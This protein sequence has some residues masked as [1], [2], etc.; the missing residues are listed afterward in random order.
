M[1]TLTVAVA[2]DDAAFRGTVADLLREHGLEVLEAADG[3]M[4]LGILQRTKVALVVT[5]LA[6][7]RLQG[8][9]VLS[10][11]RVSGDDTP[12]VVLTG[13]CDILA[14]EVKSWPRVI[15]LP[16]PV[17]EGGLLGAVRQAVGIIDQAR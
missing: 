5:D 10:L 13:I 6:M 15:L 9:D 16:K 8:S 4:L 14:R 2:D 12:F 11:L 1:T 17:T 7:P 3:A